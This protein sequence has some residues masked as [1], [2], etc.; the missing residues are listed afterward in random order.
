MNRKIRL[1]KLIIGMVVVALF[2]TTITIVNKDNAIKSKASEENVSNIENST[3]E[4]SQD[5]YEE[6]LKNIKEIKS[7]YNVDETI[8]NKEELKE[9]I[10]SVVGDTEQMGEVLAATEDS[11]LVEVMLDEYMNSMKS[12]EENVNDLNKA[13]SDGSDTLP[14]DMEVKY[15]TNGDFSANLEKTNEYGIKTVCKIEDE[16]DN[17]TRAW[18]DC[19]ITKGEVV[20]APNGDRHSSYAYEQYWGKYCMSALRFIV[21]YNVS[22]AG[23]KAKSIKNDG[24]CAR[25]IACDVKMTSSYFNDKVATHNGANIDGTVIF[26]IGGGRGMN[27]GGVQFPSVAQYNAKFNFW[28]TLDAIAY[29]GA[30]VSR[31]FHLYKDQVQIFS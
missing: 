6:V 7:E 28:V 20:F 16:S 13:I 21:Y 19:G 12:M 23:L 8:T 1:K 14:E 18:R 22:S 30:N 10:S 29:G 4:N 31:S 27:I 17:I 11:V 26:N 5:F 3:E 2:T 25:F 9:N 24:S 15:F